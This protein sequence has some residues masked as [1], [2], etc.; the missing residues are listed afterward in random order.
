[1]KQAENQMTGWV[2]FIKDISLTFHRAFNLFAFNVA[3]ASNIAV[4]AIAA[5]NA[6]ATVYFTVYAVSASNIFAAIHISVYGI[7]ATDITVRVD[8]AHISRGITRRL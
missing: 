5:G 8:I 1:M 3:D 4:Y 6:S 2:L 7:P